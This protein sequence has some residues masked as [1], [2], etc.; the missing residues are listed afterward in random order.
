MTKLI[1]R[2]KSKSIINFNGFNK[3][4]KI[5]MKDESVVHFSC[6]LSSDS[7]HVAAGEGD[8]QE[9]KDYMEFIGYNNH[10]CLSIMFK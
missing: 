4:F 2:V 5:V 10:K 3:I 9:F 6:C 7:I 8:A 1:S